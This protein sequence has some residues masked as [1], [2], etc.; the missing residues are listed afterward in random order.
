[1]KMQRDERETNERI[2]I[3]ESEVRMKESEV[4]MKEIESQM[5]MFA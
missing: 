5:H 1:M 4:R 3:K 2:R